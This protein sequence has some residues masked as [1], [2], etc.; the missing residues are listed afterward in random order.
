MAP[1]V[2]FVSVVE[3]VHRLETVHRSGKHGGIGD[4]LTRLDFV[5]LK[6]PGY[7]PFAQRNSLRPDLGRR[8]PALR[9]ATSPMRNTFAGQPSASLQHHE[10]ALARRRG[11]TMRRR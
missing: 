7:L 3:L 10:C 6:E 4:Y 9:S 1:A 5:V 2:G 8:A 11:T